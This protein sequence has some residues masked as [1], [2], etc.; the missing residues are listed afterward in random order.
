[1]WFYAIKYFDE[2]ITGGRELRSH[3]ITKVLGRTKRLSGYT[4]N[5]KSPISSSDVKRA[6]LL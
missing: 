5:L 2:Y 3:F 4:E 1:M 6:F